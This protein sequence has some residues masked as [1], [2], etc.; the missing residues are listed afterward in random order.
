M[1]NTDR[2]TVI[3]HRRH[4]FEAIESP[5]L[6]ELRERRINVGSLDA[7]PGVQVRR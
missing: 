7:D 3:R 1:E 4:L 2:L 5:R 6:V